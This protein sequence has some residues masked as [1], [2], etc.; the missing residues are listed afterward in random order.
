MKVLF[1]VSAA[2]FFESL[3]YRVRDR[4]LEVLDLIV[5]FPEMFPLR[6]RGLLAGYRSFP[7]RSYL[8]YYSVSSSEIRIIAILPGRMEEA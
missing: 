5:L 1:S 8:F 6:Q 7:V 2:E 3:P 4:A